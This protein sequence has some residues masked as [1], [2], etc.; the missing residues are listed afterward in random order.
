M[1]ENYSTK[2]RSIQGRDYL[3]TRETPHITEGSPGGGAQWTL[4]GNSA[5]VRVAT[6]AERRVDSERAVLGTLREPFSG[7]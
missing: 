2:R 5:T 6:S 7:R 4:G 1:N 3:D